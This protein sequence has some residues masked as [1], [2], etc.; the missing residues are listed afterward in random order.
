MGYINEYLI[1]QAIYFDMV[2]E[3]IKEFI[4]FTAYQNIVG[5]PAISLPLGHSKN[6]LPVRIQFAAAYGRE[7]Q[8][9]EISFELE[10]ARPWANLNQYLDDALR[11]R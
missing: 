1:V 7:K 5:A 4:P 2:F 9:L 3:R 6:G 11:H 10:E 8:L